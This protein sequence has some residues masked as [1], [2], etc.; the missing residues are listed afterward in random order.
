MKVR[1]IK[2]NLKSLEDVGKE[3]S[4]VTISSAWARQF[5]LPI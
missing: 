1:K 2:I 4:Q 5:I 3:M